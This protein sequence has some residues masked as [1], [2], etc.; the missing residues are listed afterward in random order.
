[1]N[2]GANPAELVSGFGPGGVTYCGLMPS[3]G[4]FGKS[5]VPGVH[6]PKSLDIGQPELVD[7]L[8]RLAQHGLGNVDAAKTVGAGI[9]RQRY[10]GADSHLEDAYADA[11][12]GGD[13]CMAAALENRAER[14]LID[15]RPRRVG[16]GDR[17]LV[18]LGAP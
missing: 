18:E 15:C 16:L 5:P 13:R 1:F 4:A 17:L 3:N 8:L 9:V 6:D 7:A 11:F 14:E 2:L 10:A 12:G